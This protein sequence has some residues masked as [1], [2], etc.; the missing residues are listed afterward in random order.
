MIGYKDTVLK[1]GNTLFDHACQ[2]QSVTRKLEINLCRTN[3]QYFWF[4]G[5]KRKTS[6]GATFANCQWFTATK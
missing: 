6:I 4:S 2:A 1:S 5:Y 3:I